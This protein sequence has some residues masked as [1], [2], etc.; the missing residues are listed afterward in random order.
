MNKRLCFVSMAVC[1]AV[2]LPASAA[3]TSDWLQFG[4]DPTHSG[5]NPNEFLL[6]AGNVNLL[7]LKYHITFTI[8]G[9]ATPAQGT[10]V[11]LS[12]VSTSQGVI[13]LLFVKLNDGSLFALNAANGATVWSHIPTST[14]SCGQAG[15]NPQCLITSSPAID[16]NRNFVYSFSRN[17]G[18]IHKYAIATGAETTTGGWPETSSLKPDVEKG[19]SAIAFAT[20]STDGDTYLYMTHSSFLAN[21]GGD[22]QGHITA[23]NTICVPVRRLIA[24]M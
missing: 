7:A 13:D 24:V 3:P 20:S 16:P 2:S 10:P 23:L 9:V 15:S 5:I 14:P 17:D 4:Y 8:N 11:F 12:N 1:A 22:Y 18:A 21:D 6:N 19:S